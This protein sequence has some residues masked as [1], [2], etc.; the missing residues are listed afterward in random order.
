MV[1]MMNPGG[2]RPEKD[3]EDNARD[4]VK[5]KEDL[6]QHQILAVMRACEYKYARVLNLSDIREVESP[7]FYNRLKDGDFW[8]SIFSPTRK[9][10]LKN[11]F[12]DTDNVPVLVAWGVD[13]KLSPLINLAM[14]FLRKENIFGI[15]KKEESYQYYHPLVRKPF[16][17][18]EWVTK[19][20][21]ML[22]NRNP[23]HSGN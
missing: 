21:K 23:S 9:D 17:K 2:S 16:T 6:T 12:I 19:I 18:K 15:P 14:Q 13:P 11:R 10:D 1:V 8:H 3:G 7:Q 4:F 20:V 5:T 22:K